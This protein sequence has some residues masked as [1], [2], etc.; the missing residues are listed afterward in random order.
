MEISIGNYVHYV[1]GCTASSPLLC[2]DN[3][4]E[5]FKETSGCLNHKSDAKHIYKTKTKNFT[6]KRSVMPPK[7]SRIATSRVIGPI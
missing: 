7:M 2:D 3:S 1:I 5:I 4:I 6:K